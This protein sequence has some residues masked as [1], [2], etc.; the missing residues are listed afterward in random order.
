MSRRDIIGQVFGAGMRS[1]PEARELKGGP[2][3]FAT[4][5]PMTQTYHAA[6]GNLCTAMTRIGCD[7]GGLGLLQL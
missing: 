7:V 6:K 2:L 3:M 4:W 1:I 5:C